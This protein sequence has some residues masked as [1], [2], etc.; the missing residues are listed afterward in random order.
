MTISKIL[1]S[2]LIIY[3]FNVESHNINLGKADKYI[4]QNL[5]LVERLSEEYG[6][7]VSIILGISIIESGAG[8]SKLSKVFHNHFGIVGNSRNSKKRLGFKTKYREY[9]SDSAS[10]KHFCKIISK[11]PYYNKL[12]GNFDFR[13]WY[14]QLM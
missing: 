5:E 9:S 10:F 4:S 13:K 6:I 14:I 12:R 11:K 1:F 2:F 3:S 7:P 8:S